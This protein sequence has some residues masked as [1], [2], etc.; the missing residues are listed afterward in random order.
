MEALRLGSR[1]RDDSSGPAEETY[2]TGKETLT[3]LIAI[4]SKQVQLQELIACVRHFGIDDFRLRLFVNQGRISLD[5]VRHLIKELCPATRF[6]ASTFDIDDREVISGILAEEADVIA[7]PLYRSS[8][9]YRQIPKLRKRC[10]IVHVTDGIGDLFTMWELQRAVIAK[11]MGALVK[12]ALVIP[13]LAF[14]RADLEFNL[15]HPQK[16][17][18]AKRS[19]GVGPFPMTAAKRQLLDNLFKTHQP[20]ALIIDGFD[21]SAERIAADVG[22]E[23]Y[24]ATKR[25][26]GININGRTFL[27][28]E[29]ICAEEVLEVMRPEIVVGCPS[30]SLAAARCVYDEIPVFCVTTPEA[31]KIRGPLFN[32]VFRAYAG[33]FGVTFAESDDVDQQFSTFRECLM[34]SARACA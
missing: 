9:F 8:A 19:L 26:G 12:G 6:E 32:Q 31:I 28:E 24:L 25:D 33:R 5:G 22:V 13:Q 14:S 30:T 4:A 21:L 15:F 7:F 11:S 1:Q 3:K 20:H 18:Y 17:P 29:V 10:R 27:Q 16:T 2:R 23:S 34:P